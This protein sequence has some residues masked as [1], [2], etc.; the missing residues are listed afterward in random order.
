LG[1]DAKAEVE[2]YSQRYYDFPPDPGD[3][4]LIDAAGVDT[5]AQAMALVTATTVESVSSQVKEWGAA[6][7]DEL[8]LLPCASDPQQVHLLADAIL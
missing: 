3:R 1:D 8:I 5:L 7:C 4:T 2:R 6:S